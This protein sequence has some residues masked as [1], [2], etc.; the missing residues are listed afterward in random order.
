M[1]T[2]TVT[3][4]VLQNGPRDYVALLTCKLVTGD[5]LTGF[6]AFDPT[7]AGDMG[8]SI[9]GNTL[10]PGNGLTIVRL[11]YDISDGI[12]VEFAWDATAEQT[13]YM[14]NGTG[15]GKQNYRPQGGLK[16]YSDGV[17]I[18]GATGKILLNLLGTAADGDFFSIDVFLRKNI[19]Q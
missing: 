8:W 18:A 10:Y 13:A 3:K 11:A 16:P 14:M 1:T 2:P 6:L 15:S 9:A 5:T 4:Q 7:S 17:L 12:G 19:Q